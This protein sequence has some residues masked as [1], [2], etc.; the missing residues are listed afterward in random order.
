MPS[1]KKPLQ[2]VIRTPTPLANMCFAKEGVAGGLPYRT[3]AILHRV[4]SFI[5]VVGVICQTDYTRI[6]QSTTNLP[7][8][9]RGLKHLFFANAFL[10]SCSY[11]KV[12]KPVLVDGHHIRLE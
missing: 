2:R 8:T 7:G 12:K 5:I 6:G 4:F 10:S 9:M 1:F 3:S 11:G